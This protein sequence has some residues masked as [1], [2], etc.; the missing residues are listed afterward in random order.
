MYGIN[1]PVQVILMLKLKIVG[2]LILNF[3]R[4]LVTN[5]KS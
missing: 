5:Y 1:F 3:D 4:I 2:I